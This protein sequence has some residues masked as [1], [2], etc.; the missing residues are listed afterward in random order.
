MNTKIVLVYFA[1][2]NLI[3]LVINITDKIKAK[4]NKW[5]IKESTLWLVAIIGGA[6]LSYLT[7]K[8]IRHKTKHKSFMIGFPILSIIDIALL[9]YLMG[10]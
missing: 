4:H 5:R 2:I 1:I 3:G 7:M 6:P 8:A 9:I 10:G